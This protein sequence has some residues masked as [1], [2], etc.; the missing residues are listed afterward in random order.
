MNQFHKLF[1][2]AWS[3]IVVCALAFAM[4]GCDG[5]DGAPG[6][7]G[8]TGATGPQ[9][10]EG[11][12]GPGAAITPLESCSVCHGDGSFAS[13]PAAHALDPIETISNIVF[14]TANA[15]ADLTVTFDIEADGV[16]ATNY[17]EA[18]RGYRTDGVTRF[19]VCNSPDPRGGV[20][21]LDTSMTL[22]NNGGGS[23]TLTVLGQGAQGAL[24]NRWVFRVGVGGDR[25]TR[26]YFYADTGAVRVVEDL[27]VSAAA[28]N[29]CHGPERMSGIHGGYYAAADGGEPCLVCH[30]IDAPRLASVVH[31]YHSSVESWADPVEEIEPHVT[32]PSYMNNCSVCHAE[33]AELA[34]ANSMSVSPGCFTCHGTMDSWTEYFASNPA[35][36]IHFSLTPTP[37]TADCSTCHNAA[38]IA[39][40]VLVV[41]DSHNGLTTGRGGVIWDGVDTSVTEGAK[42]VWEITNVVDDGV[43]LAIDWQATYDGVPVDPCNADLA[44]GPTFHAAGDG[45]LSMLRNYAQGDDFI[46]GMSTSSPGQ[47]LSVNVTVDNTECLVAGIATTTIPVDAVTAERGIIA[48]Q[49]KP[50]TPS[51][52]D[53]AVGQRVRAKTPTYEFMVG[54]GSAPVALRRDIVDND[55]CLKCHVGSLYQ[56][57]GNRVDNVGM[58]ILCHNSASNEKNVRVGMGVEASEAYDGRAGQT[59]E[60]KTMLHRIHS[61]GEEGLPP[62]VIYRNRGIY[63]FASSDTL[64]PNWPGTGPQVVF[65]SNDVTTNHNFHA[66]TYPRSLNE[67]GACHVPGLAVQPDQTQAMA[68]TQDAGGTVWEDQLDD[69]LQGAATTAC[70]TCHADGAAKGHAYQN[71]WQ[72]Q[73]FEEGRQTIIDAVN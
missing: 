41:T 49:G 69:V 42:F 16:L 5:K 12:Q 43:N 60:M 73:V 18:Q 50:R 27:A 39:A 59:F 64:L 45:N 52:A 40:N 70:I 53:P 33:P 47:A 72:P 34:A 28:C 62:Y 46:L 19:D 58:C 63:A 57:G 38:G 9:G 24:D 20:P 21:C 32:Y 11:P 3:V 23:Y 48:L 44:A 66:P 67:C 14:G 13:A 2:W 71:S 10:P 15:G 6:P 35:L 56:H 22:T 68:S 37:E 61:A 7:V 55:Q 51:P 30:G 4:G 36:S 29:N 26:V 8:P 1:R 17:N 31:G 65:G 54:D 25:A